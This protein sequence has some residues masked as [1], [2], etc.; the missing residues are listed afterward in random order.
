MRHRLRFQPRRPT[1]RSSGDTTRAPGDTHASRL[2]RLHGRSTTARDRACVLLALAVVAPTMAFAAWITQPSAATIALLA[3]CYAIVELGKSRI[4]GTACNRLADQR[5]LAR[6]HVVDTTSPES[7]IVANRA[8]RITSRR[9]RRSLARALRRDLD[10]SRRWSHPVSRSVRRVHL[11]RPHARRIEM[12][13]RTLEHAPLVD[14]RAVVLVERL[15]TDGDESPLL[16]GTDAEPLADQIDMIVRRLDETSSPALLSAG[17]SRCYLPAS[18]PWRSRP[19]D[20]GADL[21]KAYRFHVEHEG[22]TK[23]IPCF[24]G[25]GVG[26]GHQSLRDCFLGTAEEGVIQPDRDVGR[27]P[28][29]MGITNAVI[30]LHEAG[31]PL[32]DIR[33]AIEARY[34]DRARTATP[35]PALRDH[36]GAPAGLLT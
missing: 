8:A 36:A 5:I 20:V 7:R 10:Q 21:T 12:I 35:T 25:C 27:C 26:L 17:R 30:A 2:V 33:A 23:Y 24:C 22:L 6:D 1:R 3:L 4:T 34:A 14:A 32:V 28:D 9:Y 13:A 15:L 29:C 19:L 16:G 31:V 11:L 18:A